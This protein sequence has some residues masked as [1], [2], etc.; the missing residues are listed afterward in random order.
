MIGVTGS[1]D[2]K[3]WEGKVLSSRMLR[4]DTLVN[5]WYLMEVSEPITCLR[6]WK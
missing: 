4:E 3:Y 1:N 2:F 5:A 6:I